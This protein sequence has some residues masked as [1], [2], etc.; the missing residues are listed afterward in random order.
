MTKEELARLRFNLGLTQ[1]K[2][3]DKLGISYAT[4]SR[5][6]QGKWPIN[7][8]TEIIALHLQMELII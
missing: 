5:Y 4:Y 3:A 1:G 8:A 6:E 7:K 2:M